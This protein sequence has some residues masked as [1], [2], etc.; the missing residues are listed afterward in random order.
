MGEG[1]QTLGLRDRK[2]IR[3]RDTIRRE[4]LRLIEENGYANT[5]IEQIA[6]AAEIA[7]STFFRYFPSKESALI[8]NGLDKVA[9]DA[10]AAQPA[11]MAPLKAF[12]RSLEITLATVSAAEWHFE[13]ARLRLVLSEPA[14]KTAQLDEYHRTADRLAEAEARRTGRDARDLEVRVFVGALAGGM[15]TALDG[16]PSELADRLYRTLEFM[17][18]GMPFI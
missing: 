17:E 3:T 1:E 9:I 5:T 13:R 4:A 2:K 16:N 18:A 10:L 12:R 6:L 15:M 8:A 7:P 11:D 14:L